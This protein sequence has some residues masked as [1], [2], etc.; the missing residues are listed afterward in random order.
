MIVSQFKEKFDS[1][2]IPRTSSLIGNEQ[3]DIPVSSEEVRPW[4]KKMITLYTLAQFGGYLALVTPIVTSLSLRVAQID[5][6]N[7]TTDYGLIISVASF[8]HLFVGPIMGAISDRTTSRLGRRRPWIM[9]GVIAGFLSMLLIALSSSIPLIM[10]GWSLTQIS[11]SI[12]TTALTALLP[13]QVPPKQLG[14]LSGLVSFIQQAGTIVGVVIASLLVSKSMFLVFMV[15]ATI[16]LVTVLVLALAMPDHPIHKETL[17]PFHLVDIFKTFWVNPR[18]HPDFGWTWLGEFLVTLAQAFFTTYGTYFLI[19]RLH[20]KISQVPT[21]QLI[22]IG[23]GLVTALLMAFGGGVFSDRLG[24]RKIFVILSAAFTAVGMIVSA[25]AS[26]FVLYAVGSCL[27]GAAIGLFTAVS[28]ALMI[29][30]LPRK[31]QAAK[32]LG[33][34]SLAYLFP[35]SLAPT[36]APLLLAIG[37]GNNYTAL[38]LVAGVICVAGAVAMLQIKSVR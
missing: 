20:Y 6:A 17:D 38:Y 29:Q 36:L 31:E 34:F 37:G 3:P 18:L 21:L 13:D 32:D 15:P 35:K 33:V 24:R 23:V 30:V 28:Q 7:K 5:P 27:A 4:G 16:A 10:L 12:M 19:D 14:R 11:F 2:S 22:L 9:I 1:M 26:N 8:A 25:F